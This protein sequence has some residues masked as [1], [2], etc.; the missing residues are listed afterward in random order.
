MNNWN[1]GYSVINTKGDHKWTD[2]YSEIGNMKTQHWAG[3]YSTIGKPEQDTGKTK[4][5]KSSRKKKPFVRRVIRPKKKPLDIGKKF[6]VLSKTLQKRK[7]KNLLGK[8]K[9]KFAVLSKTLHPP[10]KKRFDF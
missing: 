10:G 3:Q 2:G 5:M 4:L 9:F 7:E 8:K 6:A 1:Q